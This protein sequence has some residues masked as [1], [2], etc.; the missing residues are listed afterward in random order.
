MI[1]RPAR[2]EIHDAAVAGEDKGP[3]R[4]AGGIAL[5]G[6]AAAH[7]LGRIELP[8]GEGTGDE[9]RENV[10]VRARRKA[11]ELGAEGACAQNR[12]EHAPHEALLAAAA[13]ARYAPPA[14]GGPVADGA[15]GGPVFS[16]RIT[17]RMT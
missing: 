11:A 3:C 16:L 14:A 6:Q 12:E 5:A 9:P 17:S 15:G 8:G 13:P 1:A 10:A 4:G 7:E 2:L